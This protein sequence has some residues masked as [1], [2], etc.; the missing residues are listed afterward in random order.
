MPSELS[1]HP[2]HLSGDAAAQLNLFASA[3]LTFGP[4][5]CRCANENSNSSARSIKASHAA[6]A[7]AHRFGFAMDGYGFKMS[8]KKDNV[9]PVTHEHRPGRSFLAIHFTPFAS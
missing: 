3:N 1:R 6:I 5:L 7:N 2:K 4:A 8:S 9:G